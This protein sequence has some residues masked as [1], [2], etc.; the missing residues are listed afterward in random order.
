MRRPFLPVAFLGLLPC[1]YL[2]AG[3]IANDPPPKGDVEVA[4]EIR[5]LHLSGAA[6]ERILGAGELTSKNKIA[7][8]DNVQM[9]SVMEAVLSGCSKITWSFCLGQDGVIPLG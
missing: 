1:F 6:E 8:L 2:Q 7:F 5:M 3:P 9:Q 4:V